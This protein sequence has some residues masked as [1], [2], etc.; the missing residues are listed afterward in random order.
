MS[1]FLSGHSALM[2]LAEIAASDEPGKIPYHQSHTED[3]AIEWAL[4]AQ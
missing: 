4:A 2:I 1:H 3:E